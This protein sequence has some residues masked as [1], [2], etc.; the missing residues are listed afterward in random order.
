M[1]HFNR[2]MSEVFRLSPRELRD[3]PP[4]Q[5]IDSSTD[6]G[7]TLRLPFNP[8]FDWDVATCVSGGP[9]DSGRRIR[10]PLASIGA[11]SCSTA[12]PA[13]SRS[14][15][16]RCRSPALA[17]PPAALGG[18]HPHRREGRAHGRARHGHRR[19]RT[20]TRER[21]A[22]RPAHP[23]APRPA[24]AGRLE[25]LRGRRARHHRPGTSTSRR[26]AASSGDWWKRAGSPCPGSVTDLRERSPRP[27]RWPRPT[28]T[29]WMPLRLPRARCEHLRSQCRDGELSLDRSVTLDELV[30]S[31]TTLPGVGQRTAHELAARI[32][33]RDAFPA[34]QPE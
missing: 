27:P 21:P 31:L 3:A 8:P 15:P 24:S 23:R 4:P 12:T 16:R 11:R 14:T 30:S 22:A 1:R 34:C 20:A 17:R 28:W 26:H 2:A 18:P 32:G 29:G 6:G 7:L 9:R 19:G 10:G 33:E 13:C 5:R 25:P